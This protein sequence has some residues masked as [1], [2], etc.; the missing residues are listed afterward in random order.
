MK[1]PFKL[2]LMK[3]K[4]LVPTYQRLWLLISIHYCYIASFHYLEEKNAYN[5]T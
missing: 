5:F 3:Q 2:E 4:E 1:K